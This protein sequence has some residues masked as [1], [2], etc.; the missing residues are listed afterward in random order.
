MTRVPSFETA[1]IKDIVNGPISYTPD[2]NPMVGPAFGLPNFWLSEGHSFGV[3]AA[4][5]AGWQ[6]ANWIVDGEPSVDMIGVDPRRFGVVSKNFAKIKNEEAYE[7]VFVNHFPMEEREAGRPAKTVPIHGR[8]DAA[9]AVWGVRFGWERPNWFAPDGVDRKDEYSF[10][11]SNWFPHVG[12]EVAAMRERVGL[13]ELSSFAKYMVEGPGARAWLDH[14]VA[15]IIPKKIGRMSLSHALNPSGSIR[16]E[17]TISRLPDGLYGERFYLVGPG[18]GHDYDWDFLVKQLPRDGSVILSD[19]TTQY[20]VLVLAGPHARKV[21][22]KL[23]D[24]DVSNEAFPWLTVQDIPLGWCPN[25]RALRVNFVG[26]LGW[27]LHHP[28]EY[29]AHLFDA[30]MEAGKEFDIG[31]VGLRAM[32]SM[33][34]EKS[35]RLW[36]TDLNAEN[37]ALEAG[38]N[39]FVRLNKGDFV[40]RDALTRQQEAGVPNTYCTLEIDADDAD[41]FGNEPVF[42]DGEVVG[43]GT[44][45]GYGHHVKKSLMLGYVKTE[46]AEIGRDCQVRVMGELRPARI[47]PESPYDPEN[48]MLRA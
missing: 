9:G 18:A 40:G 41:S 30:I 25:V 16:S 24:A 32:D 2:G 42:M 6:L 28:I 36:G 7:H 48:E 12:T 29:Q 11:R 34:L 43:R 38:L 31:L 4:G 33:R 44:A 20:G 17:F 5:G 37:S 19:L 1:G 27:E 39:R 23:A 13:L 3:T 14:M 47:V 8:L 15:N 22:E 35:Y 10:R 21:M 45:G 46:F 26:S